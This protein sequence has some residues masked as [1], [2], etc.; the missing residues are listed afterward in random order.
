MTTL[1]T[2]QMK[3]IAGDGFWEGMVCG[4]AAGLAVGMTV[5]PDPI[6]KVGL[7]AA[8]VGA[9]GACGLAFF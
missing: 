2:S 8:W 7:L 5:S 9:A 1:S 4:A 6:S 3:G